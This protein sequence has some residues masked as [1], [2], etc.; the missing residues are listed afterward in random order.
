MSKRAKVVLL[1]LFWTQTFP[2]ISVHSNAPQ[3]GGS[4]VVAVSSDPGGLNPAVTT[5]GG[6]HLI[7]GSIFSGL[8]AHDFGLNPVPDLAERWQVSPDGRTYTFHLT[9]GAEFHDG[10]PLTSEDVRFTFEQLLMKYHSRTRTSLGDNLRRVVTPDP[11]T[12][13]FEFDRPY[14]AFLQLID[15]TNAPVMPK[16]LYEGTDPL[17]IPHNTRPIGSGPFKFQEWLKGAHIT[18]VRNER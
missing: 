18:L 10:V 8:V 14:A 9:P 4:V 6:V 12:V 15:V 11:H 2:L 1:I 7:C 13:V 17:T 3:Y 16:H 5:Q